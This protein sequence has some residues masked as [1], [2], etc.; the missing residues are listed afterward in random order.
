MRKFLLA[1]H[2]TL[3]RGMYDSL[4]IICGEQPNVDVFCAY[5]GEEDDISDRVRA[6]LDALSPRDELIVLTDLFGGSVNNEFMRYLHLPNCALVAGMNLA[7]LIELLH[8]PELA[9]PELV[10][11]AVELAG[12]GIRWCNR[13]QG[14]AREDEF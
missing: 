9:V 2:G 10:P 14:P 6:L 12:G 1:S 8:H 4:R 3:A 7:L 13:L 11:M 5:V